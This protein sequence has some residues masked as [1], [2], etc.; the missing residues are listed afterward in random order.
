MRRVESGELRVES[1]IW[2]VPRAFN[3]GRFR[4]GYQNEFEAVLEVPVPARIVFDISDIE[5]T[6]QALTPGQNRIKI[7]TNSIGN[8]F[9]I[10]GEISLKADNAATEQTRQIIISGESNDTAKIHTD[11]LLFEPT[12]NNSELGDKNGSPDMIYPDIKENISSYNYKYLAEIEGHGVP[13]SYARD[14]KYIVKRGMKVSLK[15]QNIEIEIVSTEWK[16]FAD[17]DLYAFMLGGNGRVL[18]SNR[19]V[20]YNNLGSV[21]KSVR[22]L[23][24]ADK[25]A[26]YI[27]RAAL[28]ADVS[29]IDL[30]IS[31]Y[32][33]KN[34]ISFND[35]KNPAIKIKGDDGFEFIFPLEGNLGEKT[36][37]ALELISKE[38]GLELVPLGMAYKFSMDRLCGNY[39]VRTG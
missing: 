9:Y 23:N 36:I 22:Y 11:T 31:I 5:I 6:P 7:T 21:C 3:L 34:S 37:I 16:S 26:M 35:L 4:A 29:Q 14:N 28:P 38:D 33:D 27:N 30:V 1:G 13:A 19:L 18:N 25:R 20:Y 17:I 39:G 24:A 8:G 15:A 10:Y 2:G 12:A 32:D